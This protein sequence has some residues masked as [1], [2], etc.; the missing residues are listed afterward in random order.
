MMRK[1]WE[2]ERRRILRVG[3]IMRNA[4]D[5]VDRILRD[6]ARV[7]NNWGLERRWKLRVE[8]MM[9]MKSLDSGCMD[10]NTLGNGATTGAI[11]RKNWGL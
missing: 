8:A 10:M 2:L 6:G 1:D 5:C 7:R 3:A 4:L 11:M 9:M